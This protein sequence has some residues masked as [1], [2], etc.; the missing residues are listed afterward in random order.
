MRADIRVGV[1]AQRLKTY[2]EVVQTAMVIEGE[3]QL[4]EKE[5]GR[6]HV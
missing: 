5:I 1:A 3:H 2:A 4:E 6:A